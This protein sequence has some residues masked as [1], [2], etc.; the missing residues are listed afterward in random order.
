MTSPYQRF[1]ERRK[2][3]R[4]TKRLI[5]GDSTKRDSE[6][7]KLNRSIVNVAGATCLVALASG[8]VSFYQY[9]AM[10]EQLQ[11]TRDGG[12]QTDAQITQLTRSAD[13]AAK[14]LKLAEQSMMSAQRAYVGLD[15]GVIRQFGPGN[16][17]QAL[18]D[19]VNVGQ[20]PA[21][22]VQT[23]T[24]IWVGKYPFNGTLPKSANR[25]TEPKVFLL[26]DQKLRS[27]IY[28]GRSLTA[29]EVKGITNGTMAIYIAV[30]LI[31]IDAFK[32]S[33]FA[34]YR[35]YFGGEGGIPAEGLMALDKTGNDTDY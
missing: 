33:H 26:R 27:D 15:N 31:Y 21:H 16:N 5:E 30:H 29:D 24:E 17:P 35:A 9:R 14:G 4:D 23:T 32:A 7:T 1:F 3:K 28:L 8:V 13:T 25:R 22:E 11:E 19:L 34:R 20:T 6:A 2:A 18:F 12:K 10:Q